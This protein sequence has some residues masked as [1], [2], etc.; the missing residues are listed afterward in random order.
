MVPFSPYFHQHLLFC[1]FLIMAIL[2]G[3]RWYLIVILIC[4]S[5]MISDCWA[6]FTY[7]LVICM[8][9]LKKCL[10]RTPAHLLIGLFGFLLLSYINSLY[11]LDNNPLSDKWFKNIFSHSVDCLFILLMVSFAVQKLLSLI[12]SHLFIFAFVSFALGDRI[13]NILL[14]FMSKSV[15]PLLSCRRARHSSTHQ[16]AWTSL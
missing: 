14:W 10:F 9:L 8:S 12:R 5:L 13:I 3:M 1:V 15:L 7:L 6:S 2:T 16:E 11:I 4:A